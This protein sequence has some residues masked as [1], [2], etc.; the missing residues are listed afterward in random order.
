MIR[1]VNSANP[2]LNLR[3]DKIIPTSVMLELTL[4]NILL[5]SGIVIVLET[6]LALIFL[7]IAG[8]PARLILYFVIANLISL[9]GAVVAAFQIHNLPVLTLTALLIFFIT[10]TLFLFFTVRKQIRLHHLIAITFAINMFST[11]V[12]AMVYMMVAA[13]I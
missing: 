9:P 5:F 3:P 13:I 4:L 2:L 10:E 12:G 6:L 8:K 7:W 11:L 1:V